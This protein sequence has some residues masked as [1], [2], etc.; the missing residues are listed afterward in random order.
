MASPLE[1][2]I[3]R[4]YN[5][6]PIGATY[7]NTYGEENIRNLV[8]KYRQLDSPGMGLMLEV[9]TGLSRS[10]DLSSSYVSVG[11]LHA[12]GRKEEVKEAYRWAADHDDSALF[13]HHFD[14]GTSLA[15]HF[16]GPDLTA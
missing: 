4:L 5:E 11:V 15:D 12:L 14:I 6:P 8:L 16:A 1:E 9:L 7:T 2:E 13:T 10:Y 3:H